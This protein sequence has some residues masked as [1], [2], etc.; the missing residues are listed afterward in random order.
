MQSQQ[1]RPDMVADAIL[2]A[3]ALGR[4]WR[5]RNPGTTSILE[6]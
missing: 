3:D 1:V 2:A 4:A 6:A 5:K